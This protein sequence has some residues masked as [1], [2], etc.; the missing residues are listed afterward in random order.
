MPKFCCEWLSNSYQKHLASRR[1]AGSPCCEWLS[2]SY[3]KHHLCAAWRLPA[4]CEWL[5]NSYQKHLS[6]CIVP[7]AGVVNDSQIHIRSITLA[8][9]PWTLPV[10]NDSQIHIRSIPISIS[11]MLPRLWMTLKFIS[12]ASKVSDVSGDFGLWMTL[13]FI[14][15]AS[16][17]RSE[18]PR[19]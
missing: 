5:S 12:E 14:S 18:Q 4:G 15:E 16:E 17:H 1:G 19:L 7:C 9:C 13:K 10:V 3:Q 2:N 8:D 11:T 6:P